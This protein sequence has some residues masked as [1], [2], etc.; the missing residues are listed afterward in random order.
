MIVDAT[1]RVAESSLSHRSNSAH[2]LSSTTDMMRIAS[3][4]K[5]ALLRRIGIVDYGFHLIISDPTPTVLGQELLA[6]RCESCY[7]F[8]TGCWTTAG[9]ID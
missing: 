1:K 9:A 8:S 2:T 7:S 5:T 6:D 3:G 4:S